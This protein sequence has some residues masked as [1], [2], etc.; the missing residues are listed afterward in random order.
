VGD[1]PL[2][3]DWDGDG[4]NDIAVWRP[5]TGDWWVLRSADTSLLAVHWG[6]SGDI[7]IPAFP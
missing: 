6:Q 2:K 4:R 7:P 5:S 1:K 3:G